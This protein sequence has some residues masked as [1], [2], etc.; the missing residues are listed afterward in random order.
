M[1]D[2]KSFRYMYH[3]QREPQYMLILFL[4][5]PVVHHLWKQNACA[6]LRCLSSLSTYSIDRESVNCIMQC[7]RA[8]LQQ[9]HS[10]RQS[11]ACKAT[12]CTI[13]LFLHPLQIF[14][15]LTSFVKAMAQRCRWAAGATPSLRGEPNPTHT[16]V[17]R[18]SPLS[19]PDD[20]SLSPSS[21]VITLSLDMP[22]PRI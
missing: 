13:C 3:M 18:P 12:N 15:H 16:K 14:T 2:R 4:L 10:R 9:T 5:L 6:R 22:R 20:L 19:L 11:D 17:N 1:P 8:L 7:K 21:H